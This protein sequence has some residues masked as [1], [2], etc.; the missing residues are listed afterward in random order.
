MEKDWPEMDDL[1]VENP[2]AFNMMQKKSKH[3][4]VVQRFAGNSVNRS[5]QRYLAKDRIE[6]T[7]MIA[8]QQHRPVLR[9]VLFAKSAYPVHRAQPKLKKQSA[10]A[11][12]YKVKYTFNY[13]I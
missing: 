10:A 12:T 13:F 11:I 4:I 6:K 9:N 5:G 1:S 2:S 3:L 8:K 7:L